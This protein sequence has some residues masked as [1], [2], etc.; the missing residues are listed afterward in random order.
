MAD[1]NKYI[2]C[3]ACKCKYLNDNETI[4]KEFGYTRLNVRLKTCVK[5]RDKH[6][7]YMIEYRKMRQE[8]IKKHDKLRNERNERNEYLQKKREEFEEKQL[9]T[10]VDENHKCCTRCYKI[11]AITEYGEYKSWDVIDGELQEIM[12]PY[13]TCKTCRDKDDIYRYRMKTQRNIFDKILEPSTSDEEDT[14]WGGKRD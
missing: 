8:E 12:V 4:K 11:Q 9:N 14:I 3:S 5:C 10:E 2:K 13:K 6:K 7:I 1:E